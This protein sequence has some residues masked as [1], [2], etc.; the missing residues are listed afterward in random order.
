MGLK[1]I[2]ND[3]DNDV[4]LVWNVLSWIRKVLVRSEMLGKWYLTLEKW[5]TVICDWWKQLELEDEN[6]KILSDIE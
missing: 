2:R 5:D 6:R 3:V 1:T 4:D